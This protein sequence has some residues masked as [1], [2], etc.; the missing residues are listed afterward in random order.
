[1]ELLKYKLLSFYELT[2]NLDRLSRFKLPDESFIRV[3]HGIILKYLISPKYSKSEIEM[4]EPKYISDIVKTIWNASVKASCPCK[5]IKTEKNVLKELINSTFKN[6]DKRTQTYIDTKLD[7]KP[8]LLKLNYNDCCFNLRFLIKAYTSNEDYENL[9]KKFSLKLP[10]KKLLIVEGVT[11]EILLPVFAKKLNKDFDKEGVFIL[12]A[13]GKSKSPTIYMKI[14]DKLKIPVIFLFDADAQEVY[15]VLKKYI[16][17]KDSII[18]INNGEFEDILSQNLIKRSLN[19]EYLPATPIS[20]SELRKNKKMCINIEEFYK[21]RKLGEFKKSKLSKI[22]A[23]NVKYNS[24][25]T[26]EIKNIVYN[27]IE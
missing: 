10:I 5:N 6:I 8:I 17:K 25:I 1:M 9:R 19:K 2:V 22:I 15:K 12:G 27:I 7:I 24:D 11:E 23:K 16:L 20:I 4:L 26:S 21:I 3:F 13:G 18:M 14:K